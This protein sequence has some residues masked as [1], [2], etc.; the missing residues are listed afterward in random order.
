MRFGKSENQGPVRGI[1]STLTTGIIAMLVVFGVM[2]SSV[3][4]FAHHPA[5][6]RE[7]QLHR[8][9]LKV[10]W[11]TQAGIGVSGKLIDWDYFVD[12]NRST[13]YFEVAG[14]DYSETFSQFDIGP[15]GKPFGIEGGSTYAKLRQEIV[16]AELASKLGKQ[17]DVSITQYAQ[18]QTVLYTLTSG[19]LVR[20][21]DGETG[22]TLW[23]VI[24]DDPNVECFGVAASDTYVAVAAG[25]KIHCL[26][27][28]TG[29]LL[30]SKACR[31][32]ISAPPAVVENQIYV[33]LF[34]G[35]LERFNVR[36]KGF[37]STAYVSSGQVRT[38]P[39]VTPLTVSW[40]TEG[41]DFNVGSRFRRRATMGFQ[42]KTGKPVVS[43]PAYEDRT[44][45]V[46][47]RNGFLYSID[48]LT[49]RVNWD[50]STGGSISQAPFVLGEHVFV[51]NDRNEMH[52]FN[53]PNGIIAEGWDQP[54]PNVASFLGASKSS[55]FVFDKFGM[56]EVRDRD[57]GTVVASADVGN[58]MKTLPHLKSDRLFVANKSGTIRCI[59][60]IASSR[61]YFHDDEM[62]VKPNMAEDKPAAEGDKPKGDPNNPFENNPFDQGGNEKTPEPDTSNPF[63]GG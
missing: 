18:P 20:A 9:G 55:V 6:P 52:K 14:G 2:F 50:V 47:S 39:M 62:V 11:F 42:L 29:K 30:W 4:V 28:E 25:N 34:N 24:V 54:R 23:K 22:E 60:E 61:P 59:R 17:V 33:P 49:G 48:E 15:N 12:E 26:D 32:I 5:E 1:F 31:G 46:G 41:G 10:Q 51:I 3:S 63:D 45:F 19:A 53:R 40:G 8:A 35:Q 57:S 37:N 56:L 44:Y 27:S 21:L 13:T 7:K 38:R 16:A 43:Q 58:V 36:T